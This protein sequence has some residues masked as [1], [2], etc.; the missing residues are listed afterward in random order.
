[1]ES[2]AP[3]FGQA[4]FPITGAKDTVPFGT[5]GKARSWTIAA[6]SPDLEI[7]K[8]HQRALGTHGEKAPDWSLRQIFGQDIAMPV[9]HVLAIDLWI[10]LRSLP[11]A[12]LIV[13]LAHGRP[14]ARTLPSLD[15]NR[16]V[17]DFGIA[18]ATISE[19]AARWPSTIP[20]GNVRL[21]GADRYSV[22]IWS[23]PDASNAATLLHAEDLRNRKGYRK[24]VLR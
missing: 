22:E 1:M 11:N 8:S 19:R 7:F 3:R 13:F 4:H 23:R 15:L 6:S 10:D 17:E 21:E 18:T 9:S 16:R 24:L 12:R 20:L 14:S 5:F 2:E